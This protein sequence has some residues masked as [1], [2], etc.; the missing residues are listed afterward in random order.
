MSSKYD[1]K[2][3]QDKLKD[4]WAENEVYSPEN[5]P[6]PIYSVDTPPPTVSGALHIG[7][8]FSYTQTDIIARY[9]R[10][11][12]YS[13]FYPFGFDDNGLP[14]EKFVEKKRGITAHN[15]KRSEFIKICLEETQTVEK[16][17]EALWKNI[18]LSVDWKFCYSTIDDRSRA[19]SQESF[20][21][22][23]DK[24]FVYRKDEPALYCTT[25]RTSVAQAE[26][27]DVEIQTKFNTI[28][29]Q[30]EA[31]E[32]L[33]IATTRPEL[34]YSCVAIFFH[35]DD[36]RYKHLK[37]KFAIVPIFGHKVPIL[38][39]DS[40]KIDKGTGLVMCCTFGD[41][42]D[43]YWFKKHQLPYR[44]SIGFDGKFLPETKELGGLKVHEAR[45]KILELLKN[46]GELLEQKNITHTVN[47]HE[48]C[49][50]E[51]EYMVLQQWFIKILPYKKN[52]LEAA[53]K[54]NWYPDFMKS[55]FTNWVENL[56]WDWGISRQRFFGIPFP[57][58]HCNDCGVI[59]MADIQDLPIDPQ[60]VP[61][62]KDCPRCSSK[63]IRPDKDVM[64]TWNTSS[65]TPYL[66]LS[67]YSE[68]GQNLFDKK[69][70]DSLL[71]MSMRPQ[72]HDIIRTWA[73]Y[74]IVK[75]WMHHGIIPWQNIVISGHVLSGEKQKISK[76]LG[77]TVMEPNRLL[78]SFSADAIRYWTASGGLG[79]DIA[80][81]ENQI[82][83]G[84]KLT[85]KIFNAYKFIETY[86]KDFQLNLKQPPKTLINKWILTK[87]NKAFAEY[88]KNLKLN[89]FSSG[90]THLEEFFWQSFC[91]NY[92]EII[93]DPLFNPANYEADFIDEIK[94][95]LAFVGIK[96][97][98]MFGP[99]LPYITESVYQEL[100]RN[101]FGV[102]SLHQ[103]KYQNYLIDTLDEQ[104]I[105]D[106]QFI[107]QLIDETRKFKSEKQISLRTEI[108]KAIIHVPAKAQKLILQ[109]EK[110]I[111]GFTKILDFEFKEAE[112]FQVIFE[113]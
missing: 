3:V 1:H 28:K 57:C 88:D 54:I 50:K 29:F 24:G 109:N 67:L 80:F 102:I 110:L 16:E 113:Q 8:I 107:L 78:E 100:Y 99:Y 31:G 72:A 111:K 95:T 41:T 112:E 98:Q 6:G 36:P 74:T 63:N 82:K 32:S 85:I 83:I 79:H 84:Q 46:S 48:R 13:V 69:I 15:L 97:L 21:R 56:N 75:T 71:P 103:T 61:Y 22:L 35:P 44:Q 93:K 2:L 108:K 89:E 18:G 30:T 45:E 39:D 58:W 51:I 55:R 73:F 70:E 76:S 20:I 106:I 66:C 43:V 38:E 60:E 68:T 77:N 96:L 37:G 26:L 91:D 59:I 81:S 101:S 12:G 65:L 23:Y 17:F 104:S 62:K 34:L 47:I 42:T 4:F 53:D 87:L 11:S 92:L 94:N 49:K 40:V 7:H 90:L 27:E 9:K 25:D 33:S 5:N 86:I 52:F 10:M 14:T 19:I 105:Q 64:D